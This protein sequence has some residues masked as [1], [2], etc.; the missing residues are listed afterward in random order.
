MID[1]FLVADWS[2]KAYSNVAYGAWKE[3]LVPISITPADP[4]E[5]VPSMERLLQARAKLMTNLASPVWATLR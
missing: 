4:V 5:D 1:G 2:V 3:K